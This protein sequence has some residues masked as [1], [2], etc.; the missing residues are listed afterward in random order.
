MPALGVARV[1]LVFFFMCLELLTAAWNSRC[2]R[3]FVGVVVLREGGSDMGG[4]GSLRGAAWSR[5]H[6]KDSVAP[7]P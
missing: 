4:A 2:R 3:Q 6:G 1:S 7:R 5:P